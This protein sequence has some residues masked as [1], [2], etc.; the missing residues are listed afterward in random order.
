MT[1]SRLPLWTFLATT[2]LFVTSVAVSVN[3]L[4]AQVAI[5]FDAAGDPDD[6]ISRTTHITGFIALGLG[7]SA[8]MLG[9]AYIIRFFPPSTLNVPRQA[10]WRA[11]ENYPRACAFF[12]HHTF[13]LAALN[14]LFMT[15]LHQG[16]VGANS[17]SPSDLLLRDIGI[18]TGLF[19]TGLLVWCVFLLRFYLKAPR[20]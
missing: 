2:L 19:V 9:I 3:V 14:N 13:W 18:G 10:Y 17:E 12:V 15:A 11:P 8:F 6:W 1:A 5:H 20:T 7:L 16:V 4:P